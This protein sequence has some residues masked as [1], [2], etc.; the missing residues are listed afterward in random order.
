MAAEARSIEDLRAGS[1]KVL[2]VA[3][4]KELVAEA[5]ALSLELSGEW[6]KRGGT[7]ENNR[8][9]TVVEEAMLNAWKHGNRMDPEKPMTAVDPARRV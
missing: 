4:V 8:I 3:D 2:H 6:R 9:R 7:D 5:K 1:E